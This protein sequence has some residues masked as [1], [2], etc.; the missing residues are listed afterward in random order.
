MSVFIRVSR[1][2][3]N[4]ELLYQR[5]PVFEVGEDAQ[6]LL[7]TKVVKTPFFSIRRDNDHCFISAAETLRYCSETL[8]INDERELLSGALIEARDY[9][10][11]MYLSPTLSEA[12]ARSNTET[13]DALKKLSESKGKVSLFVAGNEK[14]LPLYDGITWLIGS[15]SNASLQIPLQG[16][17]TDHCALSYDAKSKQGI[18]IPR[19]GKVALEDEIIGQECHFSKSCEFRLLPLGLRLR[20]DLL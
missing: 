5:D 8:N 15:S 12:L 16:I 9:S 14:T 10:F 2:G 4:P 11:E 13:G 20:V 19:E 3:A 6:G 17:E 18:L 1:F 7:S